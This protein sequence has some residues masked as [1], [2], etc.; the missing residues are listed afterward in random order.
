MRIFIDESGTFT[1]YGRSSSLSAVGALIV[2]DSKLAG[3]EK[4]WRKLR[5]T[6]PLIRGEVKGSKLSE[7]QVAQTVALLFRFDCLFEVVAID[8]GRHDEDEVR[9]HRDGQAR[10][11]TAN[12]TDAHSVY[13]RQH[14]NDLQSR[15]CT[16]ALQNYVQSVAALK[17]LHGVLGHA[18]LY[19]V[20][21]R[22]RELGNFSWII[23]GKDSDNRLT[24]WEKWWSSIMLP[25]LQSQSMDEPGTHLE[26]ADYRHFAK[27]ES[28]G[29][30]E[31]LPAVEQVEDPRHINIKKIFED[32][33]F[34]SDPKPGL[35]MVDVLTNGVRRALIGHLQPQGW[36]PIRTLMVHR[37]QH[38]IDMI[39]FGEDPGLP[40]TYHDTL[41]AFTR[42]GRHM[43]PSHL[44]RRY[45]QSA[46][47]T[48]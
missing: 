24:P 19:Y 8:L 31:Y 13:I 21:R 35:E 1:G 2:P 25:L 20:Q 4:E 46:Q 36:R 41:M 30:P 27:Y 29:W 32:L 37:D 22:P 26:G 15:L 38:Y 34:S 5:R 14:V 45:A 10:L 12:I 11:L 43:I 16:M 3:L 28:A 18:M 23:D 48:D 40:A 42:T 7:T 17:L 33:R 44:R 39:C 47:G 9:L 6:F